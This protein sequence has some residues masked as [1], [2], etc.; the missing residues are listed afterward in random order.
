[1]V[2]RFQPVSIYA[3]VFFKPENPARIPPAFGKLEA[4]L[5]RFLAPSSLPALS[6]EGLF[7]LTRWPSLTR[8]VSSSSAENTENPVVVR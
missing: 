6:N 5:V 8:A 1:M 4:S 7:E 3:D 2:T